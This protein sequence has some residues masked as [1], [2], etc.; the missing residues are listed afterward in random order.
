M[1][2]TS[3]SASGFCAAM[4]FLIASWCE[5]ENAVKTRSPTYGWRGWIGRRVAS[6]TARATE[7][8]SEKSRPGW[9]PCE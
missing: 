6:S 7:L 4:P 5:P 2:G 3:Q 1:Y 9:M 8:M